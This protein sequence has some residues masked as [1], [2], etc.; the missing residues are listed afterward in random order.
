MGLVKRIGNSEGVRGALCWVAAQYIR[1]VWLT[2]RW[3]TVGG[4]I[5][6]PFWDRGKPF[7]LAFWHGRLLMMMMSWRRGVPISMLTSHH[8]DGQMIARTSAHFGIGAVYGSSTRG[9][10]GGARGMLKL[11]KA[12]QCVGVTPDGPKG[13][14]MRSTDG[15]ISIARM[16]GCPIIPLTY[17]VS[18]RKLLRSW[19]RFVVP[20]PFARGVFVWGE[21][22]E[23]PRDL[24]EAGVEALRLRLEETMLAMTDRAD[25]LMGVDRVPPAEV[26]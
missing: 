9:G 10:A 13:P 20:L 17:S 1:L 26:P 11:L 4:D 3:Q 15:V 2:A 14:R 6:I 16:S 8:R 23:V 12:G 18:R 22:I 5:P 21:P 25:D 7:V 19:D 24:D